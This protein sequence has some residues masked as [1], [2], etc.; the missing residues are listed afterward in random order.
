MQYLVS[1]AYS[2]HSLSPHRTMSLTPP[3]QLSTPHFD[4]ARSHEMIRRVRASFTDVQA[5]YLFGSRVTGTAH[6][7]SDLDLAILVDGY[8]APVERW[9]MAGR[10]SL[11]TGCN[12]DL[13]DFRRA[14]TVLQHQILINGMRIWGGGLS[15][16]NFE[17][18][19]LRDK[20]DLDIRRKKQIDDIF[21]SGRIYGS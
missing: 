19:V 5:I 13:I 3:T 8:I 4:A 15:V 11:S 18:G 12:V 20:F 10:L 7:D 9:K 14:S 21:S 2:L 16:E 17:L 1:S 6:A